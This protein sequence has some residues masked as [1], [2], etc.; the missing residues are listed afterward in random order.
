M[1]RAPNIYIATDSMY[2]PCI[3]GHVLNAPHWKKFCIST[4]LSRGDGDILL[5]R[6]TSVNNVNTLMAAQHEGKYRQLRTRRA[7][8]IFKYVLWEPE[9]RYHC[10]MS[11][12]IAPF[13]LSA[14][15][16]WSKMIHLPS[17]WYPLFSL[18]RFFFWEWY[19]WVPL[20][21]YV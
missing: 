21:L 11:I 16:I 20:P 14:D 17:F 5:Y 6:S 1:L 2:M 18:Y 4:A 19:F 15:D 10:T 13:W 3:M 8:S 12:T 7:L 9:G